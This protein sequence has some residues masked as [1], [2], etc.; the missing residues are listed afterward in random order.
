M[1]SVKLLQKIYQAKI[2]KLMGNPSTAAYWLGGS[3]EASEGTFVWV[4]DNR[5]ITFFDFIPGQPDNSGNNEDCLEILVVSPFNS[6]WNDRSCHINNRYICQIRV[7]MN[8]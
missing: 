7:S 6:Q 2:E 8:L 1:Q 3:D 5:D 4:S